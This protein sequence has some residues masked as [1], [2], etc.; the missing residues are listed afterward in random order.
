MAGRFIQLYAEEIAHLASAKRTSTKK[1]CGVSG[2]AW[3]I[4]TQLR[5]H[6]FNRDGYRKYYCFPS[7]GGIAR[8]LGWFNG[9]RTEELPTPIYNKVA[10]GLAQ[11]EE[12]GMVAVVKDKVMRLKIKKAYK[13]GRTPNTKLY[14]L[15][16]YKELL[17]NLKLAKNRPS[18]K[19]VSP[20]SEN[21]EGTVIENYESDSQKTMTKEEA[22]P[23]LRQK[24][25]AIHNFLKKYPT[26]NEMSDREKVGIISFAFNNGVNVF[27]DPVNPNIRAALDS[28]NMNDIQYWMRQ[29]IK[30]ESMKPELGLMNRREAE[31]KFMN[32]PTKLYNPFGETVNVN[33]TSA[34]ETTAP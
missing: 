18:Q 25:N 19:T 11:L 14:H 20:D 6:A 21:Y 7:Y 15:I 5:N 28:G 9:D 24:T 31:I 17:T 34:S 8:Q 23:L 30:G 32:D 29:F 26:Y 10:N 16:F 13:L 1:K 27:D 33:P 12:I 3:A 2:D 22:K 4:Y